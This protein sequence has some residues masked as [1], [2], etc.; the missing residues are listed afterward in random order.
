MTLALVLAA[1]SEASAKDRNRDGIPDSWES[2]NKLSLKS[3]QAQKD[4][5]R[6]GVNNKCEFQ[7]GTNPRSTDSD[8]DRIRDGAE[9]RD[10]DG[11]DNRGESLLLS[12][13][14]KKSKKL[15]VL[16][17]QIDS[18]DGGLV[19]ISLD[20]GGTVTA[21]VDA[22]LTCEGVDFLTS[23]P[24][25]DF[26]DFSADDDSS[27]DDE[28]PQDGLDDEWFDD[29]NISDELGLPTPCTIDDL[30]QGALVDMAKIRNGLFTAISF[31]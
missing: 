19:K 17:G 31:D 8:R 2:Q 21:P 24:G 3:N 15:N 13:C 9:D 12:N 14:G 18:V 10:R 30:E 6:D 25:S 7:A 23:A 22:D 27:A 11:F 29:D 16:S 4:Q 20:E 26:L 5:D 28:S 1:T